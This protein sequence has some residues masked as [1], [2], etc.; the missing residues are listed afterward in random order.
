[1]RF[2][3]YFDYS[4]NLLDIVCWRCYNILILALSQGE[5]QSV[6]P[7]YDQKQTPWEV[8]IFRILPQKIPSI[9]ATR[10]KGCCVQAIHPP[11]GA[12]PINANRTTLMIAVFPLHVKKKWRNYG[13]FQHLFRLTY[14]QPQ[15][16]RLC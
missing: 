12:Q 3:V 8:N 1:M 7:S 13:K 14:P 11:R 4:K 10:W 2:I 5:C 15:G 9:C 6:K 16:H